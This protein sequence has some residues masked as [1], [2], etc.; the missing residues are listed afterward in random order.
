MLG[1]SLLLSSL[2]QT[3]SVE[4]AALV[5]A[6]GALASSSVPLYC[7]CVCVRLTDPLPCCAKLKRPCL[8]LRSCYHF[9]SMERM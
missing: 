7:G 3:E 8:Q 9:I 5:R 6:M 4:G 2:H 1:E